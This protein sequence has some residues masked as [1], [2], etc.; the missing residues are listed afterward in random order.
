L[1]IAEHS[2]YPKTSTAKD[3]QPQLETQF[4]L[5]LLFFEVRQRVA[6][7]DK[8]NQWSGAC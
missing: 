8:I 1:T 6:D 3:L 5:G 2:A 4:W 7:R